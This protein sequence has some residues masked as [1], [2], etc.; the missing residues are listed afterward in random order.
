MSKEELNYYENDG[1]FNKVINTISFTSADLNTLFG[2]FIDKTTFCRRL[3]EDMLSHYYPSSKSMYSIYE[4][5][6]IYQNKGLRD[7]CFL[8]KEIPFESLDASKA[9]RNAARRIP[10]N[11]IVKIN[12]NELNEN[13]HEMVEGHHVVPVI[14]T[15][16]YERLLSGEDFF[17][18]DE[19]DAEALKRAKNKTK[20][21]IES[22]LST[23]DNHVDTSYAS[24]Y[25]REIDMASHI[26]LV[27][28]M[29]VLE[30]AIDLYSNLYSDDGLSRFF[31]SL[32]PPL[33]K[34]VASF[35]TKRKNKKK[36]I[37]FVKDE[38]L[39]IIGFEKWEKVLKN[40]KKS[41]ISDLFFT[42]SKDMYG[43]KGFIIW[44]FVRLYGWE[45]INK[46]FNEWEKDLSDA[47]REAMLI[48]HP[49]RDKCLYQLKEK[50]IDK[51]MLEGLILDILIKLI[52]DISPKDSIHYFDR[53]KSGSNQQDSNIEFT[54]ED[55]CDV[56]NCKSFHEMLNANG[57][58][59]KPDYDAIIM[60]C[61]K[62]HK[63]NCD[64]LKK[65]FLLSRKEEPSIISYLQA[66]LTQ[67]FQ[68]DVITEDGEIDK[69]FKGFYNRGLWRFFW[70]EKTLDEIKH[71]YED[72]KEKP[73][74]GLFVVKNGI[75]HL[76]L[77]EVKNSPIIKKGGS[78]TI[79]KSNIYLWLRYKP[80]REKENYKEMI[81]RIGKGNDLISLD[82]SICIEACQVLPMLMVFYWVYLAFWSKDKKIIQK[83]SR[84]AFY[85]EV[86]YKQ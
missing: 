46:N 8:R 9:V 13:I 58:N 79:K 55:L 77:S 50:R 34:K 64:A 60:H 85:K 76:Q 30:I 66:N 26:V 83:L 72:Y 1:D 49:K 47:I 17:K 70:H 59:S 45:Y 75:P 84:C 61:H 44:T 62:T 27:F 65:Y 54:T 43:L 22:V 23:K 40:Q 19:T 28:E 6:D 29:M 5:I 39:K 38:F 82:E 57:D 81:N 63:N 86:Q 35:I 25:Q 56:D 67:L 37:G 53:F 24:K 31:S 21:R 68:V 48:M 2:K 78:S 4:I 7:E 80:K 10:N 20:Q 16:T 14:V 51:K 15:R 42:A 18:V 73:A 32:N 71:I 12:R 74:E 33:C 41:R 3:L 69:L 52:I 11:E 36:Y